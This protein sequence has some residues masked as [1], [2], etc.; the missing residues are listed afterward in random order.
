MFRLKSLI[1]LKAVPAKISFTI[2]VYR[3]HHFLQLIAL[4]NYFK[5][6]FSTFYFL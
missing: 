1:A 6:G 5:M 3:K 4:Y 2:I